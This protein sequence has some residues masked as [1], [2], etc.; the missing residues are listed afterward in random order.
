MVLY[1]IEKEKQ[2]SS[3]FSSFPFFKKSI[4]KKMKLRLHFLSSY[5]P[6]GEIERKAKTLSLD[7]PRSP[8]FLPLFFP[9]AV[10]ADTHRGSGS[11]SVGG[12]G[13]SDDALAA[14]VEAASA[15]PPATTLTTTTT[16][17]V[18][19]HPSESEWKQALDA[20]VPC[21]VVLK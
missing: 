8:R 17:A 4:E 19:A 7:T 18:V 10:M 14:P 5:F 20:V 2:L 15:S 3:L 16:P 13:E 11:S 21:V 12:S 6:T 9:R 1:R